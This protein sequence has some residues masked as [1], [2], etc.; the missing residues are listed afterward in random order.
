MN[1][2]VIKCVLDEYDFSTL[3]VGS[4]AGAFVF[5]HPNHLAGHNVSPNKAVLT[6]T[7]LSIDWDNQRFETRNSIYEWKLVECY[8]KHD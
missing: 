8:P 7:V 3:R 6:S 2:P 5:E 4:R 1:K